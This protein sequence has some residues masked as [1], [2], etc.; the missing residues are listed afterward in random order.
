MIVLLAAPA[1]ARGQAVIV[2][3]PVVQGFG[4]NTVVSVPDRGSV[5]LGGGSSAADFRTWRGFGRPGSFLSS[6]RTYSNVGASVYIHD[7][8]A[9][10]AALLE[11][12]RAANPPAPPPANPLAAQAMRHLL[13]QHP[14]QRPAQL[15]AA[16]AGRPH[17]ANRQGAAVTEHLGPRQAVVADAPAP[18]RGEPPA[19]L[20][21]AQSGAPLRVRIYSARSGPGG[22]GEP[23]GPS[24]ASVLSPSD[25]SNRSTNSGESPADNRAAR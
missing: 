17:Q 22:V 6:T 8:E 1:I 15:N 2:Q 18:G 14:H 11:A 9:M 5:Q 12:A 7:L 23:V 16:A 25:A 19:G 24:A 20:H 4:A 3:Q 21:P 10:D 13:D